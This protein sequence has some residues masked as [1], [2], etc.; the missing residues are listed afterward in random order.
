MITD[1]EMSSIAT[2]LF[3]SIKDRNKHLI[4][5]YGTELRDRFGEEM[6]TV[7]KLL[8]HKSDVENSTDGSKPEF[9]HDF[10]RSICGKT[11]PDD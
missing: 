11:I 10:V 9:L 4:L 8:E 1:P 3:Q 5:T 2:K 6:D 7:V